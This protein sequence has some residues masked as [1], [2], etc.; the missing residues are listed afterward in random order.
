MHSMRMKDVTSLEA[1]LGKKIDPEEI[2][3]KI[4]THFSAVFEAEFY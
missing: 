2:K 3:S 1:E 4:L